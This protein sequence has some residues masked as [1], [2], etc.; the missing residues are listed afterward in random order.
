MV[1]GFLDPI[2]DSW[3]GASSFSG[4]LLGGCVGLADFVVF[5]E[6]YLSPF[7]FVLLA[8]LLSL[9]VIWVSGGWPHYNIP[10]LCH[11]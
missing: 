9:L 7:L 4:G 11:K 10:T 3:L 8:L 6:R 2:E 1:F 5:Q